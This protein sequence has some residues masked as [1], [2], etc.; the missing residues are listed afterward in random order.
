MSLHRLAELLNDDL[1]SPL[2]HL[3]VA[4][5]ATSRVLILACRLASA[6]QH[7]GVIYEALSLCRLV[8]E[9]EEEDY[10][11]DRGFA[12]AL[13]LFIDNIACSRPLTVDVDTEG[14]VVE[15]LFGIASRIRL[16][17]Q[18]LPVWFRPAVDD[19]TPS[20]KYTLNINSFRKAEFPLFYYLLDYV[21]YE[22]RAG[23][24]ARMGLLYIIES[25]TR[26]EDLE[27]WIIESDLAT[28]M[29]SGLGALYS[30]LSRWVSVLLC[31]RQFNDLPGQETRFNIHERGNPFDPYFI[32]PPCQTASTR[33]R[34]DLFA[35]LSISSDHISCLP[36]L[37]ARCVRTLHISGN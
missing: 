3:C 6:L 19:F 31:S 14:I 36:S 1:R 17:P 2:P 25:A 12:A 24:F 32:R 5:A 26:S 10:L 23:E 30:Q 29:A 20:T 34:R 8:I 35:R 15:V 22:G 27:R 16:Q 21:H 13:M 7:V 9:S 4:F 28:L 33:Y 18:I 11:E 37:L